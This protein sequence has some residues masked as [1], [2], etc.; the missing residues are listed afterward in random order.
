[1]KHPDELI[2]S[3]TPAATVNPDWVIARE[4][5]PSWDDLPGALCLQ[6]WA[7]EMGQTLASGGDKAAWELVGH[8]A[9][10]EIEDTN[11][12]RSLL[13]RVA[14]D[15]GM[16]LAQVPASAVTELSFEG[17]NPFTALAPVLVY[18]EPGA[19]LWDKDH[20]TEEDAEANAN[21][22][23]FRGHLLC[24]LQAFQSDHPVVLVS[25][26]PAIKNVARELR[27]A[28]AMDR[29]FSVAALSMEDC[30]QAF[31]AQVGVELCGVSIT[32][33]P[34]KMGEHFARYG[35]D[36]IKGLAV[37]SL[38]RLAHRENR[39]LEFRDLVGFSTR[40]TVESDAEPFKSEAIRKQFAYHEA[41]HAL[42]AMLDS[43]GQSI[44]E[45]S[46][47]VAGR[48]FNGA[49]VDSYEHTCANQCLH[50]YRYFRHRVRVL[51]AGR[52]AEHQV[53]G[54]VNV[55]DGASQDLTNASQ[56]AA[57]AFGRCGFAPDMET[58][59]NAGSNLGVILDDPTPSEAAHVE[60]LVRQFMVKEYQ[61]VMAMLNDNRPL[62][63]A[64]AEKLLSCP[65]VY[66]DELA[67]L[68]ALYR[69][70]P[71]SPSLS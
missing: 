62:L 1:M 23:G 6:S 67:A 63:N 56:D 32:S 37:I 55:S 41:G 58:G 71:L 68:Y 54:A 12:A 61:A 64:I 52:A 34:I 40:G 16:G 14:A 46:T 10:I 22:T 26:T 70:V 39:V 13:R 9:L 45:Y 24:R 17:G 4:N 35:N 49:I 28:G 19:W 27:T 36:R 47:I 48:D 8:G 60:S 42:V 66:Q 50:T 7:G 11:R 30:G 15:A 59:D 31:I 38:R 69:R 53:F 51:L 5:I 20:R 33:D 3:I 57:S 44:P 43:D 25:T 29:R 65:A 21:A 2:R 18:L